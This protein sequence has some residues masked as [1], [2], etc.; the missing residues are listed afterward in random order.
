MFWS[1]TIYRP[2]LIPDLNQLSSRDIGFVIVDHLYLRQLFGGEHIFSI[3][4][5]EMYEMY[6]N[7][8]SISED[9]VVSERRFD[10]LNHWLREQGFRVEEVPYHGQAN[11]K[12]CYAV[13]HFLYIGNKYK[14]R[15]GI[16]KVFLGQPSKKQKDIITFTYLIL[17]QRNRF[18]KVF[19]LICL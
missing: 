3:T 16:T 5:E 7:V 17:K 1:V 11:R 13:A 15:S 10:R 2:E 12:A 4:A 19:Y 6:S 9:V 14:T 8:F 18:D